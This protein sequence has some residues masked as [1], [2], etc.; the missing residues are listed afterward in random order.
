M[1]AMFNNDPGALAATKLAPHQALVDTAKAQGMTPAQLA[2]AIATRDVATNADTIMKYAHA[3]GGISPYQAAGELG[4]IAASQ[5]YVNAESYD[6][7]RGITGEEG[8]IRTRTSENL[9]EAAKFAV[10]SNLAQNIGVAKDNNDF[11]GMYDYN[12]M[13]HGEESLTLTNQGAV[14]KLNQRMKDMGYKNV[15]FQK[16]DRIGMDFDPNGNVISAHA[17]RGASRQVED[18]TSA[19]KGH[20]G[21]YVNR[22]ET[23]NFRYKGEDGMSYVGHAVTLG[24]GVTTFD[25]AVIGA[26]GTQ[27]QGAAKF[28][29]G[30]PV[31]TAFSGGKQG[32]VVEKIQVPTG[33][34]GKDGK[35]VLGP[36]GKPETTAQWGASTYRYSSD[37]KN[38]A[39]FNT[40]TLSTEEVNKNGFAATIE[41]Q[42]GGVL[43]ENA[44]KGQ[45]VADNHSYTLDK[46]VQAEVSIGSSWFNSRDLTG[47]TP[48]ER[49]ALVVTAAADYSTQKAGQGLSLYGSIKGLRKGAG[50]KGGGMGGGGPTNAESEAYK[51]YFERLQNKTSPG[52]APPAMPAT[53]PRLLTLP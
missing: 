20:Q 44:V 14:D 24:S 16:G 31:Y 15:H 6:K 1:Q 35:P 53:P 3:R 33:R 52:G 42:N 36:D 2:G 27:Y 51:Q 40:N 43:N 19:M 21:Q 12:K 38:L 5:N 8:Q 28:V 13:H 11:K 9:N 37:G 10:L 32:E 25:G 26:D 45:S 30:K 47:V 18:V 41:S 22:T 7:A 29:D 46:R 50:G 49:K 23:D 17:T 34:T 39:V 48:L 4:E